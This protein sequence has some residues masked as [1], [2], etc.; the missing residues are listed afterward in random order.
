MICLQIMTLLEPR[1]ALIVHIAVIGIL[2]VS[3]KCTNLDVCMYFNA[4]EVNT[5]TQSVKQESLFPKSCAA[6]CVDRK[7]CLGVTDDKETKTCIY[8]IGDEEDRGPSVKPMKPGQTLYLKK[9]YNGACLPVMFPNFNK[10]VPLNTLRP[11]Q[12][13]RH[14]PDI[15]SRF[16]W[17]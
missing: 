11:R 16:S 17:M 2:Q 9:K 5:K 1:H 13:G 3:S 7:W 6:A 14:L 12:N 10:Y 4:S 8:H 15:L